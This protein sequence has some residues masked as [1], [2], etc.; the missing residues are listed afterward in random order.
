MKVS[1]IPLVSLIQRHE[2]S[3]SDSL[4][5]VDSDCRS[6]DNGR[7][8]GLVVPAS[9]HRTRSY[10]PRAT[11]SHLVSAGRLPQRIAVR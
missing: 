2:N 4:P 9:W 8:A 5:H 3:F 7:L 10:G 11:T 1:F 6:S